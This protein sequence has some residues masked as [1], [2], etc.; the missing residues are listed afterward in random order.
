MDDVTPTFPTVRRW[1]RMSESDQDALLD[2]IE[3]RRRWRTIRARLLIAIAVTCVV[4]TGAWLVM[5]P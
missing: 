5:A 4:A 2:K 1:R 3:A